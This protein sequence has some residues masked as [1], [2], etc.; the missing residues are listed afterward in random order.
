MF[1]IRQ[2]FLLMASRIG[3]GRSLTLLNPYRKN[4]PGKKKKKG[5]YYRFKVQD[6][7]FWRAGSSFCCLG[8]HYGGQWIINCNI[9]QKLL[10]RIQYRIRTLQTKRSYNFCLTFTKTTHNKTQKFFLYFFLACTLHTNV[11][12]HPFS[13]SGVIIVLGPV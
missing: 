4:Y 1:R 8:V 11:N 12:Q 3:T 13:S 2:I 9:C 10:S 6:V 5:E 7:V